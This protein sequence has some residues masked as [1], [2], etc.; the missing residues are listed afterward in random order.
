M[1]PP[2]SSREDNQPSWVLTT[3]L[4]VPSRKQQAANTNKMKNHIPFNHDLVSGNTL[5]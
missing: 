4:T 1:H 2:A 3:W 5:F